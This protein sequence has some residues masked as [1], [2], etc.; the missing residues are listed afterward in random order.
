MSLTNHATLTSFLLRS[1]LDANGNAYVETTNFRKP[2]FN[3]WSVDTTV[4]PSTQ[5]K[6]VPYPTLLFED[7]K[8]DGGYGALSLEHLVRRQIVK[9]HVG[10]LDEKLLKSL[11]WFSCGKKV[12]E[13]VMKVGEDSFRVFARFCGRFGH[14]LDFVAMLEREGEGFAGNGVASK[15]G[16]LSGFL[17]EAELRM[18]MMERRAEEGVPMS[19]FFHNN[20]SS[21]SPEGFT[22]LPLP[23]PQQHDTNSFRYRIQLIKAPFPPWAHMIPLLTSPT[24]KLNNNEFSWL[25]CLELTQNFDYEEAWSRDDLIHTIGTL[26]N[27]A[28]LT[29]KGRWFEEAGNRIVGDGILTQWARQAR[30]GERWAGLRVLA[31]HESWSSIIGSGNGGPG[32]RKSLFDE[33]DSFPR[34]EVFAIH[35]ER[36]G[37]WDDAGVDG[38]MARNRVGKTTSTAYTPTIDLVGDGKKAGWLASRRDDVRGTLKGRPEIIPK[39]VRDATVTGVRDL[40]RAA[41]L[42]VEVE[43]REQREP[44]STR[45]TLRAWAGSKPSTVFSNSKLSEVDWRR[46]MSPCFTTPSDSGRD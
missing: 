36:E 13:D 21:S 46:I 3:A 12:W 26:P 43:R 14:E 28:A 25:V 4:R 40:A 16:C 10:E 42:L 35:P 41:S 15:V 23:I 9:H 7:T 30:M 27:L 44:S 11:R 19:D 38:R 29:L 24:P 20:S 1:K 32:K 34:L 5:Y 31:V 39:L 18:V 22:P 17:G 37:S 6:T 45:A 8:E 33:L 2:I